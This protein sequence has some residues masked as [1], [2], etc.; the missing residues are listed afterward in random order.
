MT[1]RLQ[2]LLDETVTYL[3]S[4]TRAGT[5]PEEARAGLRRI[6]GQFPE[7]PLDLVWVEEGYDR[8]VHYDALIDLPGEGTVSVSF[9][10]HGG[11]PWP[12]RGVQRW[13]DQDLLRVNGTV[14]T[15]DHAIA[16]VDFI[17]DETPISR[18]L[19]DVC[20]I[21]EALERDPIELSDAELQRAM[22]AFRRARRLLTTEATLRWMADKGLTYQKLERLVSDDATVAKLRERVAA[23]RIESHFAAHAD[24][25]A[26]LHALRLDFASPERAQAAFAE[27]QQGITFEALALTA[28]GG[29]QPPTLQS[30]VLRRSD[31]T[32]LEP[33]EGAGSIKARNCPVDRKAPPDLATALFTG[34]DGDVVGPI[35]AAGGASLVRV[36][37]VTQ[38]RLDAPTQAVIRRELFERWLAERRAGASIEWFWGN[39]AEAVET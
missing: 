35:G 23:G 9:S 14:L 31:A 19:V 12:L 24:E 22:D 17:W 15:V 38:A 26:T 39:A 33:L 32:S 28:L 34:E 37:A 29:E 10:P 16:C 20:L 2:P 18:R 27:I 25:F 8:S 13:R 6:A 11:L 7:H 36:I 1:T 3:R 4:V 5:P 21:M 30:I